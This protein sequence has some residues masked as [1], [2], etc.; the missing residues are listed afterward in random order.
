MLSFSS[1]PHNFHALCMKCIESNIPTRPRRPI[2][3][4]DSIPKHKSLRWTDVLC[5]FCLNCRRYTASNET[6]RG[7]SMIGG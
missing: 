6:G 7:P 5:Y 3:S 1:G 2:Y 4:R